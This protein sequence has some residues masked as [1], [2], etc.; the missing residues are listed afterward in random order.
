MKKLI[1]DPRAVVRELL[2][3]VSDLN[4]AVALLVTAPLAEAESPLSLPRAA[5]QGEARQ[6]LPES[7]DY[8]EARSAYLA[9]LPD[10]EELFTFSDFSLF[11]IEPKSIRYVAGFGRAM[12]LT[13]QRLREVLGTAR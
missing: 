5:I 12:S 1:N 6:C 8:P 13:S 10:A 11:I 3:G 4:P 9:K 2:E 7:P